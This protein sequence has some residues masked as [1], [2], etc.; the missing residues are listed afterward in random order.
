[1][2]K[3]IIFPSYSHH[4]ASGR[5]YC[6][7][8]GIC[9]YFGPYAA[10]ESE[11]AY[12][13]FCAELLA[14][15]SPALTAAKLTV[16]ELGERFLQAIAGEVGER[17]YLKVCEVIGVASNLF[18][19]LPAESFGP[20]KLRTFRKLLEK[21]DLQPSTINQ[22]VSMLRKMF[23]WGVGWELVPPAI[24]QALR[25]VEGLAEPFDPVRPAPEADIVA[26]LAFMPAGPR[27]M[28]EIQLLTAMRC[29]EVCRLNP[30]EI[31]EDKPTCGTWLYCPAEHKNAHHGHKREIL[32]GPKA[33][34][35][36]APWLSARNPD[37][38]VFQPGDSFPWKPK[39]RRARPVG[40]CYTSIS[41]A[42][43]VARA[44]Q[45]A[46]VAPWSPGQLRH[47]AASRLE[48]EF[49]PSVA[50][51]IL[52]HRTLST[53]RIYIDDDLAKAADA[54]KRAG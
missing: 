20:A 35:I 24:G 8:K 29:G 3:R 44:C 32:I 42:R 23:R 33:Q 11:E 46:G 37:E 43:A 40:S 13:R 51:V 12:R 28:C 52:G 5:G 50:R 17:H 2:P 41:Y 10:Q 38:F 18:G 1:M 53:S 26:A 54:M 34:A 30:A 45:K 4:K 22:R 25:E 48:S 15:G 16:S 19:S 9:Y 6:R 49:G 47:N 7:W 39:R 27:T 14:T 21:R 36:L 31:F